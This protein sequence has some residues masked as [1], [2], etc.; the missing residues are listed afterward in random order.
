MECEDFA[1]SHCLSTEIDQY[2]LLIKWTSNGNFT[3]LFFETLICV[4]PAD[5]GP[6]HTTGLSAHGLLR[7]CPVTEVT[8]TYPDI[9]QQDGMETAQDT[10]MEH[11]VHM[12]TQDQGD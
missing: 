1:C 5:L 4:G 10:V 9:V 8:D 2:P 6:V 7:K 12:N 3:I 11:F